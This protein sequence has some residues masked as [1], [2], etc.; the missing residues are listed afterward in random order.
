MGC[1]T[2]SDATPP[3]PA[4]SSDPNVNIALQSLWDQLVA[5]LDLISIV[6]PEPTATVVVI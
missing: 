3:S 4:V 5:S 6:V 2:P 1:P